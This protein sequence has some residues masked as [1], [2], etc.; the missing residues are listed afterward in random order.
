MNMPKYNSTQGN[1][2]CCHRT[3]ESNV[4][5]VEVVDGTLED[6]LVEVGDTVLVGIIWTGFI[7][8]PN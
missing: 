4:A 8:F 3:D 6:V 5:G 2:D 7:D 1:P